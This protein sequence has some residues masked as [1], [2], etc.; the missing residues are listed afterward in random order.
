MGDKPRHTVGN[1]RW[2]D[3][4][5][6]LLSRAVKE[7]HAAGLLQVGVER[8]LEGR[9]HGE[10]PPSA[11]ADLAGLDEHLVGER[12]RAETLSRAAMFELA[13]SADFVD[14]VLAIEVDRLAALLTGQIT[15]LGGHAA[16]PRGFQDEQRN[17][18]RGEVGGELLEVTDDEVDPDSGP[19]VLKPLLRADHKD[20]DDRTAHLACVGSRAGERG[21]V[22]NAK[23]GAEPHEDVLVLGHVCVGVAP[24]AMP[25]RERRASAWMRIWTFSEVGMP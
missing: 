11:G 13:I 20:R 1:R 12:E 5:R 18:E 25:S 19:V 17:V 2:G 4:H 15:E 3:R 7:P 14:L 10:E 21:V 9:E 22:A 6:G 23:V 24:R 16:E 8:T